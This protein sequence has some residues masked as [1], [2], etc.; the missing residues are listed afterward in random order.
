MIY[1]GHTREANPKGLPDMKGPQENL[2]HGDAQDKT[3]YLD[4]VYFALHGRI[5]ENEGLR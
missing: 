3:P 5:V 4:S 2:N 1:I